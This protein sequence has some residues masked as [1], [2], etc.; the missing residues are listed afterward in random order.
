MSVEWILYA[1]TPFFSPMARLECSKSRIDRR[2]ELLGGKQLKLDSIRS[3]LVCGASQ[4]EG[5]RRST[6]MCGGHFGEDETARGV[7]DLAV[8]KTN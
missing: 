2:D 3:R 4:L 1:V 5:L 8:G 7:A 6:L